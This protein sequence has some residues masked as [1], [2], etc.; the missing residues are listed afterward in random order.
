MTDKKDAEAIGF[1]YAEIAYLLKRMATPSAVMTA[2]VLRLT[3]EVDSEVLVFAGASSL[4]GREFA[5]V[6]DDDI[7]ILDAA[8]PVSYAMGR[9]TL[10]T[11]ISLMES[12]I[13]DTI[14]HVE[15]DPVSL[16]MQPRTLNTWFAYAQD[17]DLSGPQAQLDVVREHIRQHPEGTAMLR[18]RIDGN[19]SVLLVRPDGITVA[20]G[21]IVPGE[22][23][24]VEQTGLTADGLLEH[25][26]ELRSELAT[27]AS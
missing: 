7:E 11:E 20:V 15:S 1:G 16:L 17:P 3:E 18:A 27:P 5:T 26:V 2:T 23:A 10:W 8:V 12:D 13:S 14:V 19:D 24:V 22:D 6:S 9:A 21:R 4:L 25:L